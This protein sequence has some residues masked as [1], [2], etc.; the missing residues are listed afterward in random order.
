MDYPTCEHT[1]AGKAT[2]KPFNFKKVT[3]SLIFIAVNSL[4][5][6]S[7]MSAAAVTRLRSFLIKFNNYK[8]SPYVSMREHFGAH[9]KSELAEIAYE[10]TDVQHVHAMIHS[11][12]ND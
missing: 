2:R 11:L 6:T 12:P 10:L 3:K 5:F 7:I 4:C 9:V 8:K 1:L